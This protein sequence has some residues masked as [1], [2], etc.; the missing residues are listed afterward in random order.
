MLK[1]SEC[2]N[3]EDFY[4]ELTIPC[5]LKVDKHENDLGMDTIYDIDIS[6][7]SDYYEVIYC[8]KCQHVVKDYED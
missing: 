6:Q 4:R 5:K 8:A 7:F 1:C 3:R 2:G